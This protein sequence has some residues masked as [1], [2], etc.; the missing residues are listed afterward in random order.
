MQNSHSKTKF[1]DNLATARV[2]DN[3]S[4]LQVKVHRKRIIY[5]SAQ[6]QSP[7]SSKISP[8]DTS[9]VRKPALFSLTTI[10]IKKINTGKP[11]LSSEVDKWNSDNNR[12]SHSKTLSV[13]S[14]EKDTH[15]PASGDLTA[16][17]KSSG[18]QECESTDFEMPAQ[19]GSALTTK[20]SAP[21]PV[22][23]A[24][25]AVSIDEH[26]KLDGISRNQPLSAEMDLQ[27][28]FAMDT[29]TENQL[30]S[31]K[32]DFPL[33]GHQYVEISE[34]LHEA[35]KLIDQYVFSPAGYILPRTTV[36]IGLSDSGK[37]INKKIR[38]RGDCWSRKS[39]VDKTNSI[40][41][42]PALLERDKFLIELLH[43]LVHA[44]DDGQK[45]HTG[46]FKRVCQAIGLTVERHPTAS[47]ELMSGIESICLK[48][49]PFPEAFISSKSQTTRMLKI[50]CPSCGYTCRTTAKWVERGL[51]VCPCMTTM[52]A[53]GAGQLSPD[54]TSES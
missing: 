13:P 16:A 31:F 46:Y 49:P 30:K 34:W 35:I 48:L 25:E 50:H 42:N 21:S 2:P 33:P 18:G 27:N 37:G 19:D 4:D 24:T 39:S 54:L 14:T 12:V 20:Q 41:L 1:G 17:D 10:N 47:P 53:A 26:N 9:V 52:I 51:P 29:A 11:S 8:T 36:T 38:Q 6:G 43:Q 32:H 44:L 40:F 5:L 15:M 22:P 28:N 23:V 7:H 45:A 3:N